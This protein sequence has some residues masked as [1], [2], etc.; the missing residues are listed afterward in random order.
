LVQYW[1]APLVEDNANVPLDPGEGVFLANGHQHFVAGV[2][3]QILAGGHQGATAIV[4]VYRLHLLEPHAHQ[5]VVLDDKL[6]GHVVVD[7]GDVLVHGVFLF[8]GRRLHVGEGTAH[9]NLDVVAAEA[10]GG[11]AA[12]HGGVAA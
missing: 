7:D 1:H 3:G 2:K 5:L 4:V 9:D 10:A 6:L 12:I 11:A 8:P